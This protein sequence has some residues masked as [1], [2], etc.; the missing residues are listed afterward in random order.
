MLKTA[1]AA[2]NLCFQRLM[3]TLNLIK[4]RLEALAALFAPD[5]VIPGAPGKGADGDGD[6]HLAAR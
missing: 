6:T 4:G 3:S 1:K 2:V 5:A